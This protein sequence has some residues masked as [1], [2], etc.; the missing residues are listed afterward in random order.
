MTKRQTYTESQKVE[1]LSKIKTFRDSGDSLEKA[2]K[3]AGVAVPTFYSW[4]GKKTNKEQKV[5]LGPAKSVIT[6]KKATSL[7]SHDVIKSELNS[8]KVAVIIMDSSDLK[9][10]LSAIF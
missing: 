3:K 2:A 10:I 6:R 4:S 9:E 1:L 8:G 7:P 5:G